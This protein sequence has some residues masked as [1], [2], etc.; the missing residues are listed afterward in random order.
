MAQLFNP[1]SRALAVCTEEH[2]SILGKH[3]HVN[4][5][6]LDGD[7]RTGRNLVVPHNVAAH[8]VAVFLRYNPHS[9]SGSVRAPQTNTL[10]ALASLLLILPEA[11]TVPSATRATAHLY[12]SY[13]DGCNNVCV[14][15][16]VSVHGQEQWL[17]VT[18]FDGDEAPRRGCSRVRGEARGASLVAGRA[19]AALGLRVLG[20]ALYV[21][22]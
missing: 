3:A 8:G 9:V 4:H 5:L 1:E 21:Q 10:T 16:G 20:L 22:L 6:V 18:M 15:G 12:I 14:C 11:T 17:R 2:D 19:A 7:R 13:D